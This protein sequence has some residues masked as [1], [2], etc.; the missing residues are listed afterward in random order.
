M[1]SRWSSMA[2][3]ALAQLIDAIGSIRPVAGA[4]KR[5]SQAMTLGFS[6]E[7]TPAYE[8]SHFCR[9]LEEACLQYSL[10]ARFAHLTAI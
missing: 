9:T 1:Y 2:D 4:A 8:G 5:S 10:W 3:C 6:H 7:K